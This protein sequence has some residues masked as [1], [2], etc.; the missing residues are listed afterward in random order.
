MHAPSIF[1]LAAVFAFDNEA[2]VVAAANDTPA[3]LAA[4]VYTLDLAR[5]WR[6]SEVSSS[7]PAS[8]THHS[9]P[10]RTHTTPSVHTLCS[11]SGMLRTPTR[12]TWHSPGGELLSPRIGKTPLHTHSA[13]QI[14]RRHIPPSVL[15]PVCILG[16]CVSEVRT[17][18]PAR[19]PRP[20]SLLTS[21]MCRRHRPPSAHTWKSPCRSTLWDSIRRLRLSEVRAVAHPICSPSMHRPRCTQSV[22]TS[23]CTLRRRSSTEWSA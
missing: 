4:Y 8:G 17:P 22:H 2:A 7:Q 19:P 23:P 21:S 14:C 13:R 6:V 1:R 12:A 11:H 9:T 3:G 20:Q 16:R 18:C 10:T 5:A 15:T